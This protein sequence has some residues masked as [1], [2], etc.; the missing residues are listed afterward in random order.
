[1]RPAGTIGLDGPGVGLVR[2]AV[3]E[4]KTNALIINMLMVITGAVRQ[5]GDGPP[6]SLLQCST[7]PDQSNDPKRLSFVFSIGLTKN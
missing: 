2:A 5:V 3:L 4:L 1:M 7:L 6:G